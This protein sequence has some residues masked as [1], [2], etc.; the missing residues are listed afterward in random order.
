MEIWLCKFVIRFQSVVIDLKEVIIPTVTRMNATTS[1]LLEESHL[2]RTESP[3]SWFAFI[4]TDTRFKWK[5]GYG[6]LLFGF[7]AL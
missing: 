3:K 6:L 2:I 4:T 7:S 1:L 5:F